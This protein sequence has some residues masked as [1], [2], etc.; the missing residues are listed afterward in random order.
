MTPKHV[1]T[2]LAGSGVAGATVGSS[3]VAGATPYLG[4][5]RGQ[6]IAF[7]APACAM[8]AWFMAIAEPA[9]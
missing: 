2:R 9:N 6:G 1:C 5:L 8:N 4:S 7:A 3:S